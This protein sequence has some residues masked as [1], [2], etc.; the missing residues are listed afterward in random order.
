MEGSSHEKLCN[1]DNKMDI[2]V[3]GI[4]QPYMLLADPNPSFPGGLT[5]AICWEGTFHIDV[6]KFK[7]CFGVQAHL[8]HQVSDKAVDITKTM[9][10]NLKFNVLPRI[11]IWPTAFQIDPV[12]HQD[13]A[14]YFLPSK[15]ERSKEN[16]MHLVKYIN[17]NDFSLLSQ[18]GNIELMIFSSE[19]LSTDN[20]SKEM[21]LWGIFRKVRRKN[22]CR[23]EPNA[24]A[25][26]ISF[27]NQRNNSIEK[28]FNSVTDKVT[29]ASAEDGNNFCKKPKLEDIDEVF[30]DVPPGFSSL[31]ATLHQTNNKATD[32]GQ[33]PKEAHADATIKLPR[34][35]PRL[36]P[37]RNCL[38][39]REGK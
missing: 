35:S 13:V 7:G 18:V 28:K 22:V 11:R 12:D 4:A 9:D 31:P 5:S 15:H 23:I 30:P 2:E 21:Y 27:S 39:S 14:L 8:P 20:E 37:T 36:N 3:Q 29:Q 24:P 33:V 6:T 17:A 38:R 25:A 10:A 16:Y 32:I 19:Q 26:T 1:F 34:R